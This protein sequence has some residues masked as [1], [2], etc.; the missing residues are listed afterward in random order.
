MRVR[1]LHANA[2]PDLSSEVLAQMK[3]AVGYIRFFG[4]VGM[5]SLRLVV[6]KG[7][8]KH[9]FAAMDGPAVPCVHWDWLPRFPSIRASV[10]NSSNVNPAAR[11]FSSKQEM[12]RAIVAL[13][14]GIS[15]LFMFVSPT[16][17]GRS[18]FWA[19]LEI[20][21]ADANA[22]AGATNL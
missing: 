12:P 20:I 16:L 1:R 10:D 13:V 8:A 15:I 2:V 17:L 9:V 21:A 11:A 19:S 22:T 14:S 3:Y 5:F 4:C 18:D 7:N 6:A